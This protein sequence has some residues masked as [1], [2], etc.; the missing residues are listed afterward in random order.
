MSWLRSVG[1]Y[2]DMTVDDF[3]SELDVKFSGT[4]CDVAVRADAAVIDARSEYGAFPEGDAWGDAVVGFVRSAGARLLEGHIRRGPD[5]S[6]F[7]PMA[8]FFS[9][10]AADERATVMTTRIKKWCGDDVCERQQGRYSRGDGKNTERA[11]GNAPRE[12]VPT[13]IGCENESAALL[14]A[15][16]ESGAAELGAF[17][18]WPYLFLITSIVLDNSW[19]LPPI[20]IVASSN[21]PVTLT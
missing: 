19:S 13:W 4:G 5:G 21:T 7:R 6:Q 1:A 15:F 20:V 2:G 10:T 9:L 8:S 12:L 17:Q 18:E 11:L 14:V 16:A 3:A